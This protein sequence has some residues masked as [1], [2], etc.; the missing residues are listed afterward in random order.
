[1]LLCLFTGNEYRFDVEEKRLLVQYRGDD[2]A[3]TVLCEKEFLTQSMRDDNADAVLC[4]GS[5]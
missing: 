4:G 5:V 3:D 2:T 1:V